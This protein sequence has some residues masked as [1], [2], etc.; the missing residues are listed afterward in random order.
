[1]SLVGHELNIVAFVMDYVEF[2]FN[3]PILRALTNPIVEATA[4]GSHSQS[5]V[6]GTLF[7]R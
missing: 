1:M 2:H 4:P 7:V 5:P 3:G 6:R